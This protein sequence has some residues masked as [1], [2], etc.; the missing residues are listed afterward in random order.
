[1]SIALE[2]ERQDVDV[3]EK[4]VKEQWSDDELTNEWIPVCVV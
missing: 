3:D 2:S 1:M 4:D